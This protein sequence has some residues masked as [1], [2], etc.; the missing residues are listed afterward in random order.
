[1]YRTL[2]KIFCMNL[3][4]LQA[5]V[6]C[7]HTI[8]TKDDVRDDKIKTNLHMMRYTIGGQENLIT[9]RILLQEK[10]YLQAYFVFA[11]VAKKRMGILEKLPFNIHKEIAQLSSNIKLIRQDCSQDKSF[12][13]R[14]L[15]ALQSKEVKHKE[16][17][18]ELQS[19]FT[20]CS[21]S[22]DNMGVLGILP[23]DTINIIASFY[24][25]LSY[26]SHAINQKSKLFYYFD[27]DHVV[28]EHP[29]HTKKEYIV[30]PRFGIATKAYYGTPAALLV[31][32]E[33]MKHHIYT[34]GN[35]IALPHGIVC[36]DDQQL[37]F[38][39]HKA[40]AIKRTYFQNIPSS[41]DREQLIPLHS[42]ML[43]A[44]QGADINLLD[45]ENPEEPL[46]RL[47]AK[48]PSYFLSRY[49]VPISKSI[50]SFA[51]SQR[52]LCFYKETNRSLQNI[53][54]RKI[55]HDVLSMCVLQN[56]KIGI[57]N[58]GNNRLNIGILD[59]ACDV[60]YNR[61]LRPEVSNVCIPE[62]RGL[63]DSVCLISD[64][65]HKD[66]NQLLLFDIRT[67][68]RQGV[69]K[70]YSKR[71]N[72][73]IRLGQTDHDE[74]LVHHGDAINIIADYTQSFRM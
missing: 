56:N 10:N 67:M 37:A 47:V 46:C 39:T 54:E 14:V 60:T 68:L 62:I 21:V 63:S 8:N 58:D 53:S 17:N 23:I 64:D 9:D 16:A 65:S 34:I 70:K 20:M 1:M 12:T 57:L 6:H 24:R 35:A 66:Y 52:S 42:S 33:K 74:V 29:N 27:I 30:W 45:T 69:V 15:L 38:F 7:A 32:N 22:K 13:H 19:A 11:G 71:R 25:H 3:F 36:S 5:Y 61:D 59:L 28:F 4:L 55:H 40:G 18:N 73:F 51:T 43:I 49:I 2:K 48:S 50:F 41:T 26:V 31:Q 72:R 44:S